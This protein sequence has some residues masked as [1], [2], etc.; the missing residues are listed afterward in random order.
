LTS[1][2]RTTRRA[3]LPACALL[4]LTVPAFAEESLSDSIEQFLAN[5]QKS[6][7]ETRIWKFH[8]VPSFK[9]SVIYTDNVYLNDDDENNVQL[10]HV[11][12]PGSIV[13]SDPDRL[14]QIAANTPEFQD[15]ESLGRLD[16][17]ILQSELSTDFVL[18]VNDEYEKAFHRKAMTLLG[19]RVRVQEYLDRN[20][21]DNTSVFLHTDLFGFINDLLNQEWGRSFWVRMK[22]DYSKLKDPLD[23]EI[24]LLGQTGIE[25]VANFHDFGR[26]ENTFN[27]DTGWN[28]AKVDASAG[29]ENYHLWLDDHELDQAEHVRHNF[30]GEIG[31]RVPGWEQQRAY[32]RYDLWIY[33]FAKAPVR[34]LDGTIEDQQI[35]NDA[36]VQ[37][38]ALGVHGPMF[39]EKTTLRAEAG[40]AYWDPHSDGLSGDNHDY[41]GFMGRFQ[42]VYKPWDERKSRVSL[43]YYKSID[44]SAISNFN[45]SHNS[46]LQIVHEFVPKRWEADVSL[47]F[48]KT[49]PS[50]GPKRKLFEAGAGVTYH[51]FPQ[52]DLSLR[53]V[54][55]HQTA[56]DEIVTTSA[57][58][59]GGRVYEYQVES[60]SEFVQNIVELSALLY[61]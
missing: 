32:L 35:L 47:A 54:F 48:T 61:F 60:D 3:L 2:D 40:Y 23:T 51:V 5:T 39:S 34:Q 10:T 49:T 7:D 18:P 30:H 56:T 1:L 41:A 44:Y 28:G 4:L 36:T 50:D 26:E 38:G 6:V 55:R 17:F 29:Y 24:R 33:H 20:E 46:L 25:T 58:A 37:Q 57:F 53:Y 45:L 15:T 12:G 14:E 8:L 27:F 11:F 19:V 22:D 13:I 21:L 52:M 9:Q 16:D 59:R 42:G 31:S 43:E